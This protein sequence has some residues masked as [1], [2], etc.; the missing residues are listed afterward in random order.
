MAKATWTDLLDSQNVIHFID[1][2]SATANLIRGY[3]PR[4]DSAK[5]VGDYWHL[6]ARHC[7]NVWIEGGEQIQHS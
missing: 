3:S 5:I 4:L 1:N 2:D 7:I 6:A